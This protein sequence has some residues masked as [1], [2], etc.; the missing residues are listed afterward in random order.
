M[1]LLCRWDQ[2]I[3]KENTLNVFGPTLTEKLTEEIYGEEGAFSHD[4]KARVN[5]PLSQKVYVN[6]G[7][8]LPRTPL[9]QMQE[10]LHLEQ[11]EYLK[12]GKL[13][14]MLQSMFNPILIRWLIDL[15]HQRINQ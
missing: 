14:Q 5:H 6:R 1:F 11:L 13:F 2:S 10:I 12:N 4:W 9:K 7:G 3:G 8:T 15:K